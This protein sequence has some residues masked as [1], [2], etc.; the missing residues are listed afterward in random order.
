MKCIKSINILTRDMLPNFDENYVQ[1]NNSFYPKESNTNS[2]ITNINSDT[3]EISQKNENVINT[4]KAYDAFQD[5]FSEF[6][7]E[8]N[9]GYVDEDYISYRQD[10]SLTMVILNHQMESNGL[11][12][13]SFNLSNTTEFLPF[14]DNM[15]NFLNENPLSFDTSSFLSFCDKFEEK[16]IQYGCK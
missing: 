5:T 15:R 1:I 2:D 12:V 10:I 3:I 8:T 4:K 11:S 6:Y 9:E 16:L 14:L 13:P 7:P